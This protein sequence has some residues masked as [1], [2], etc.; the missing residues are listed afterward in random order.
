MTLIKT[1]AEKDKPAPLDS[2]NATV[3][4]AARYLIRVED[5]GWKPSVALLELFVVHNGLTTR[6]SLK[7][8]ACLDLALQVSAETC[9]EDGIVRVYIA[10]N[11]ER[12]D[13]VGSV[14][15]LP[16]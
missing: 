14:E 16:M 8:R 9:L 13:A 5:A 6:H 10:S 12:L 1:T 4:G 3:F 7:F 11:A 15:L 2:W